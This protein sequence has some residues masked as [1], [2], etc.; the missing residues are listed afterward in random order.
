MTAS[1][2][3]GDTRPRRFYKA[4]SV[5]KS[6]SG[7]AVRLDGRPLRTPAGKEL[8]LPAEALALLIAEEWNAQ[9]DHIDLF[10]MHATRLANVALDRTPLVRSELADEAA[11]YAE[12]DLVCHLAE[13]P[14]SLQAQQEAA[15]GPLRA[16]SAE[17]LG[18][19]L[20]TAEGVLPTLQPGA[21]LDAVR[22]HALSLDD[23]RLTALVHAVAMFGSAVLGL[24]VE[25]GRLRADEALILSRIDE[26]HQAEHWGRDP[27]IEA[28]LAALSREAALLGR[29][30]AA[31]DPKDGV[32]S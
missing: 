1:G 16:W 4:A 18:V 6:L 15:W 20:V 26:E 29:W 12:T 7:F 24:A 30:F 2:T 22:R 14:P 9:R 19:R 27:E 17:A 23:F 28:R 31:L 10:H 13:A 3:P 25:R 5:E 21:S 32:T 8:A 11:R